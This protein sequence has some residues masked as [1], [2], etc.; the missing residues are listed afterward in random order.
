MM[1]IR[2][3]PV[4]L[5]AGALLTSTA[6]GQTLE[7]PLTSS[8]GLELIN[9]NADPVEHAGRSGL[10][11]TRADGYTDGGTLVLIPGSEF[12]NGTIELEIAGE[13]AP[14]AD[15]SMRGFVGVAFRVDPDDFERYECF[16]L[17]PTN[18]RADNQLQRNHSVQYVSHPE[19]PWYRLREES[20]GQYET[21]VDLVPGAWTRVRVEVQGSSARLYVHG[22]EQPTL[23]VSDLKHGDSAGLVALWLHSSTLAH[24]R[25]LRITAGS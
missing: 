15:A 6:A 22:A 23:V 10:R 3:L 2:M 20:P 12:E 14:G 11:V 18:G 21:Y 5:L 13:P 1:R 25:E 16:Y 9:V 7:N 24:F 8:E 4:L 19:F 17:R